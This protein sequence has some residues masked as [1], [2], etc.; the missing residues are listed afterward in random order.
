[1]SVQ[2]PRQ[3]KLIVTEMPNKDHPEKPAVIENPES[4]VQMTAKD[5]L[6]DQK[7]TLPA[8]N[9]SASENK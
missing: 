2:P 3:T 7:P 6:V 9:A 5:D 8:E 4:N 1:M